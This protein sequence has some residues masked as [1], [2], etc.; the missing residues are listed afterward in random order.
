MVWNL[1]VSEKMWALGLKT[2]DFFSKLGSFRPDVW[3]CMYLHPRGW[4]WNW[5]TD[6]TLG[7]FGRD[8]WQSALPRAKNIYRLS[9]R[10]ICQIHAVNVKTFHGMSL[11]LCAKFKQN[12]HIQSHRKLFFFFFSDIS[13]RP[14]IASLPTSICY[15]SEGDKNLLIQLNFFIGTCWLCRL[16]ER[17]NVKGK[18]GK[19]EEKA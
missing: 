11:K 7:S 9:V 14:L 1:L 12:K 18:G 3:F 19:K 5:F 16:Q 15:A 10:P 4:E 8:W 6:F 13:S 17:E 2:S